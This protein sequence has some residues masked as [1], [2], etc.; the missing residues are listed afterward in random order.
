MIW[1][2]EVGD[3]EELRLGAEVEEETDVEAR[4]GQVAQQLSAGVGRQGLSGL[5]LHDELAVNDDVQT[6]NAEYMPLV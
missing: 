4:G 6:L 3:P 2:G 1:V 5:E